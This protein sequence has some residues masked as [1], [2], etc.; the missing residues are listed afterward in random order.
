[1]SLAFNLLIAKISPVQM[2]RIDRPFNTGRPDANML[3]QPRIVNGILS[4]AL[5]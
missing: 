2:K 5:L 1:M 4:R 3:H